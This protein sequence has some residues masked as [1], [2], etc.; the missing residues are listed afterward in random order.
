MQLFNKAENQLDFLKGIEKQ[1]QAQLANVPAEIL[2]LSKSNGQ[3]QYYSEANKKRTYIRK[4]NIQFAKKLA[5]RD[6]NKKLIP[7][8][9]KNIHMIEQFL[10]GY[11]PE[12]CINCYSNLPMARKLLVE[13]FFVDAQSYAKQWQSQKYEPKKEFPI[14]NFLTTKKE[15]VRSKSEIIIANMLNSKGIPYHYEFPVKINN[16]LTLYPDFYCLNKRTRQEFY[17]EHCG[18]MDNPEYAI[19]LVQ[20]L[21]LYAQKNII[22]GKNLILTMETREQPL[23][24]KD[25][26]RIIQAL[27]V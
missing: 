1:I 13:P 3:L 12:K 20:R 8:V 15:R 25:V 11:S 26:E 22:V 17:W 5:Q 19:R 10:K 6:Y 27:F 7:Y 4:K 23:N 2:R 9:R 16:S 18:K 21:G 14:E 24:T